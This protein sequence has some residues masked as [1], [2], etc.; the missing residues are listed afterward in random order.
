M[1]I[2]VFGDLGSGKNPTKG[3]ERLRDEADKL[4]KQMIEPNKG[5]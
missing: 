1:L 3:I 5:N 4:I 2:G